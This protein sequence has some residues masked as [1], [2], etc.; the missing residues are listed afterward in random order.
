MQVLRNAITLVEWIPDNLEYAV[1]GAVIL[2]GVLADELVRRLARRRPR[3]AV[4][5]AGIPGPSS[6]H[7]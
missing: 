7:A 3:S 5:A 4:P 1:I 6:S 2:V